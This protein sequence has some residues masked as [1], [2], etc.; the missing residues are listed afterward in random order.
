VA[1]HPL[2][3]LVTCRS[4][5]DCSWAGSTCCWPGV[6]GGLAG[7][8]PAGAPGASGAVFGSTGALGADVGGGGGVGSGGVGSG[9]VGSGGVGSGAG[10]AAGAGHATTFAAGSTAA[11]RETTAADGAVPAAGVVASDVSSPSIPTTTQISASA[12][13]EHPVGPD[14]AVG[15]DLSSGGVSGGGVGGV[16]RSGFTVRPA[17]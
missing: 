15:H 4:I 6:A 10:V 16:G 17:R 1:S 12:V 14:G 7:D 9:G 8:D 2:I 13:A 11:V 3:A 5:Q